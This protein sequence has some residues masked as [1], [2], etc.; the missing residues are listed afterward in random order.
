M[1]GKLRRWCRKLIELW[2]ASHYEPCDWCGRIT[3]RAEM[4]RVIF[5]DVNSIG[6][7]KRERNRLLERVICC[8]CRAMVTRYECRTL[9][10]AARYL[11]GREQLN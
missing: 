4:R 1:I 2:H 11:L 5:V 3:H 9:L 7:G 8:E 10:K 6:V